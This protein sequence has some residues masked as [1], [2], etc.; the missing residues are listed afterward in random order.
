MGSLL[1]DVAPTDV[2]SFTAA[3]AAVLCIALA[4]SL[5]PAWRAARL[6]PLTALRQ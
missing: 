3:A 1:Y 5:V 2:L 6:N 4:A